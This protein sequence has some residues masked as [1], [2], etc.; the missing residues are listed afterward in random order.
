MRRWLALLTVV[1]LLPA[2]LSGREAPRTG[3]REWVTE[4]RTG[5]QRVMRLAADG[6]LAGARAEASRVYLDYYEVLEGWYGTGGTYAREPLSARIAAGEAAFHEL[7]R[8]TNAA[9]LQRSA[10]ELE[11]SLADLGRLAVRLGVPLYPSGKV[12]SNVQLEA[13][14][15]RP[16]VS[17]ELVPWEA[18]LAAAEAA[19]A[20]GSYTESLRLVEQFYLEGFEPL[21]SRLP[22][23]LTASIERIIHLQLRPALKAHSG[24]APTFAALRSELSRADQFLAQGA[25]FWF[26]AANSL[27]IIVREGLE[28]VLLVGALLAYLTA[29]RATRKERRRIWLGAG[30]GVIASLLT[31]V[32]ARTLI[33]I[34]G[35]SR[36]LIEG[37]TALIA[38]GVLL[39][40]SHWLFQKTYIHD[41]KTYLRDHLGSA[42]S[43]GS[44]FA[45]MGLA[46]AAVF[47]EGFETVLFY[48]A[49]VFDA[50]S[51][52]VLAGFAPG[53]IIISVIGWA[54]IRAG[55]KLPLKRVFAVTNTI[56]LY[57]AFVFLGKGIFNLQ[58]SGAF[59]A[60]PIG[61]LPSHP[62]LQQLFGFYPLVETLLAQCALAVVLVFAV[63]AY[64]VQI[65]RQSRMEPGRALAA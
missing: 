47:R 63:L 33:P 62:L 59:A 26:G 23:G 60:H 2:S 22:A 38:V 58:E 39:Y 41:W 43:R 57:L 44:A 45:M 54:V 61:W 27:I 1:L 20:R 35:A 25:S 4:A 30:A 10:R 65:A 55:L 8:S 46:F 50:G 6:D 5:L 40:V 18:S 24:S 7:L 14:P 53:V 21:E 13:S 52:A 51:R 15:E 42:L 64:R 48:Q 49:L 9:E 16:F 31:W 3:L 11:A 37:I 17:A 36:E 34:G 28:A 19:H 12:E 56:L 29:A 32:I